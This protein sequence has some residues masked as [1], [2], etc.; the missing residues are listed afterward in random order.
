[1]GFIDSIFL[2]SNEILANNSL[3]DYLLAL[4]VFIVMISVLRVFKYVIIHRL[5][6]LFAK[7]KT[8]ID[9]L[10][11]R[12]IDSIGWPFY[13]FLSVYIAVRFIFLPDI[14]MTILYYILI[15]LITYY[16]IRGAHVIIDFSTHRFVR[17]REKQK[18]KVDTSVVD[19]LG[20]VLKGL[21]WLFALLFL[22]ASF[23]Y[24]ITPAV[25]GLGVGGIVIGFAL[26]SVLGDIFAS[27]SIYFDKPF[28]L[29]D[30]IVIGDDMGVVKKIG[31]KTTRIKTLRGEELVISNK[32]LTES[33]IHNYKKMEKRRIAFSFGVIYDTPTKKLKKIPSIVKS[34]VDK[35]K[36]ADI[37]RVHFKEFGDFSLNFEVVYYLNT[38][39]YT[40]YMDTQQ[41]INLEI[42]ERFEKEGIEMA[43]PTQ[44][45]YV[46]KVK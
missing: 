32:E 26:Q 24:N 28:E 17:E 7:T 39:D 21:L 44:T 10:L 12:V 45:V 34:I 43:F 33:R 13:A 35:V 4:V 19:L 30:F 8:E 6:K 5:K 1:M 36:L 3:T 18:K 22:L 14:I 20:K 16:V 2:Y 37:D 42:K 46:N 15:I 41:Q 25:A 38:R 11:I 31:I 9:D 29:G 40:E 23:G 27:F